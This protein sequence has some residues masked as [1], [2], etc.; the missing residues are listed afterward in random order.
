MSNSLMGKTFNVLEARR[1]EGVMVATTDS[2]VAAALGGG[3]S[4]LIEWSFNNGTKAQEISV[5]LWD[6]WEELFDTREQATAMLTHEIGHIV[7]GHLDN[8]ATSINADGILDDIEIEIAADKYA[9]S[10]CG[11]AAV[12][13]MLH[14]IKRKL[15]K[16]Y[17]FSGKKPEDY[18]QIVMK[19]VELIN[20][21]IEA[22]PQ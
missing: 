5:L 6:E 22:L 9:I 16:H 21:R 11:V 7:L 15:P 19:F 12:A 14:S 13:G 20:K 18:D 17:I 10:R 8:K 1:I 3:F 2:P 4:T